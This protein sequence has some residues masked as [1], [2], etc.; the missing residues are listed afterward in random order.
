METVGIAKVLVFIR[1]L[2]GT[3]LPILISR[4]S[5]FWR[6]IGKWSIYAGFTTFC[7]F[8]PP[9]RKMSTFAISTKKYPENHY[10]YNG[11]TH[12]S[13]S[14]K[15][16]TFCVSTTEKYIFQKPEFRKNIFV[17]RKKVFS[18][19]MHFAQMLIIQPEKL[20][21]EPLLGH[22]SNLSFEGV[23]IP[24]YARKCWFSPESQKEQ[25]FTHF[26]QKTTFPSPLRQPL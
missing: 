5:E 21:S 7:D 12:F 13:K 24:V 18:A 19:K 4:F 2:I 14:V 16:F 11:L 17:F 1:V 8:C 25:N 15:Y 26:A 10:I 20:I 23:Q 9:K 22:F 6:N 3:F